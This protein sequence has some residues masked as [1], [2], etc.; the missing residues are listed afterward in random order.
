MPLS[1]G[2]PGVQ[3]AAMA[4]VAKPVRGAVWNA[5]PATVQRHAAEAPQLWDAI[6]ALVDTVDE[7]FPPFG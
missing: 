5:D 4:G 2:T 1:P 6:R 7:Q 3:A